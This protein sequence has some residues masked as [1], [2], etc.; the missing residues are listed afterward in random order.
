[1]KDDE[2]KKVFIRKISL[3]IYKEDDISIKNVKVKNIFKEYLDDLRKNNINI[4]NYSIFRI[5]YNGYE[6]GNRNKEK[7]L[8]DKY[9]KRRKKERTNYSVLNRKIFK[10]KLNNDDMFLVK[11]KKIM[12]DILNIVGSEYLIIDRKEWQEK[13]EI[14][15]YEF[16]I[17]LGILNWNQDISVVRKDDGIIWIKKQEQK[18]L[19]KELSDYE[20]IYF[21]LKN[22]EI[23]D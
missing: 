1:M 18:K 12:I 10:D 20:E 21:I 15:G 2:N 17:I 13:Y 19:K 3:D 5:F 6:I 14:G 23:I 9:R 22:V 7:K 16:G 4:F 11:C 8:R